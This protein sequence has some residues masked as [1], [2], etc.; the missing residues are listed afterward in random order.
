MAIRNAYRS[1]NQ[2]HCSFCASKHWTG[3]W[4]GP[5]LVQVCRPCAI[6]ILPALA[7]DALWTRDWTPARGLN[8]WLQIETT[9]W[10]ALK[11]NALRDPK[12]K[13]YNFIGTPIGLTSIFHNDGG[14]NV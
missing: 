4:I 1:L 13:T 2:S 7:A 6:R 11:L 9:F 14:R 10:H 12:T 5:N 8:D 3:C